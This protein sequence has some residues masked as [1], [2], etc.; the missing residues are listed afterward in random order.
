[1][2]AEGRFTDPRGRPVRLMPGLGHL[3]ARVENVTV[4]PLAFEYPFWNERYPEALSRFG[5]PVDI[6]GSERYGAAEWS[7][8]FAARLEE[9][10]DQLAADAEGRSPEPFDTLLGGSAG[11]G[12]VYDLWRSARALARGRRFDPA[13][14]ADG[15]TR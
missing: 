3:A 7:E 8:L 13:H 12:G 5:A 10:M 6:D 11:V 9:T 1:M 15:P 2:T 4:V 14:E